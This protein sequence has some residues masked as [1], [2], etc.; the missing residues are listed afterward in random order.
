MEINRQFQDQHI[1]GAQLDWVLKQKVEADIC[2]LYHQLADY[3]YIMGDLYYGDVFSLPYWEFLDWQ[4]ID[5]DDRS[6]IRDGCL[7][8]ILAMCCEYIDGSGTYIHHYLK[9]CQRNLSRVAPDDEK[10]N[11]LLTTVRLAVQLA[12]EGKPESKEL[13]EAMIWVH[14]E[15]VRGYFRKRV[16]EFDNNPYFGN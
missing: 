15:Y 10:S 12:Q 4:S 2:L 7:V 6:F 11:R 9:V 1:A 16:H 5:K 14:R 8:M 13:T 3:S